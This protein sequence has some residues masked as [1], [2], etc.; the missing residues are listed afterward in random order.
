MQLKRI[1]YSDKLADDKDLPGVVTI[2]G[3][4]SQRFGSG[5]VAIPSPREVDAI[6]KRVPPGKLITTREI[7][8]LVAKRH[9]ATL[10]C[11]ITCGI[12]AWI[13]AHAAEESAA[14]GEKHIT[15]WW[16]TL[17][18]GGELNSKYPGGI[19][20]LKKR[21]KKEGHRIE[22]RGKR[23]FVKDFESNLAK[24]RG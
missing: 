12:F 24:L 14:A 4:M 11:P 3:K 23:F 6:M 22:A 8:Q 20:A 1:T 15:P 9:G 5:T 10:G 2:K 13:A 17:K 19:D 7:R 16:R 21:L 18:T